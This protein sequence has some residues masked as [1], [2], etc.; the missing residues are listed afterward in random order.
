M[1]RYAAIPLLLMISTAA[2]IGGWALGVAYITPQPD[3][4]LTLTV[5]TPAGTRQTVGTYSA[6]TFGPAGGAVNVNYLSDRVFCDGFQGLTDC[7]EVLP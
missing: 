4:P 1:K 2:A 6:F 5:L 7:Y 3:H